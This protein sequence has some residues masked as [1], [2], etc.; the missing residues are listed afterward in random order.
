MS[1][2]HLK[3]D[4]TIYEPIVEKNETSGI[5][6]ISK[7]VLTDTATVFYFDA[8]HCV[9]PNC[10]F[11][12]SQGTVLQ[13]S[14]QTYKIIGCDDIE[15]GKRMQVSESGH[16][17][18]VIYFEPVDKSEKTVDF[19][20]GDNSEDFRITGIKLFQVPKPTRAV[21][22]TLK[23]EVIGR[24]QSSRLMLMKKGEDPRI[25]KKTFIPIRDGKFEYVLY[26]DHEEL[27]DLIFWDE[28]SQGGWRPISFIS[29]PEIINFTLYAFDQYG[30]NTIEGGK[31]N[32]EYLNCINEI[33]DKASELEPG[34]SVDEKVKQQI[35]KDG[36]I[37]GND[38]Y[39]LYLQILREDALYQ[40]WLSWKL[41]YIK[42][43][44]NIVGYS[45]LVS[46]TRNEMDK[47]NNISQYADAYQTLFASNYPNH[48]YTAKMIDIFTGSSLKAGI[49]FVDFS[50]VD[51]MGNPVRLSKQI[52]GKPTVLHLWASWC[53]PCRQKGK[54]LIPIYEEFREKGFTVVGVAREKTISTAEAVIKSDKFP[55]ENLVELN[56]A[57]QIWVKYGIGNSGGSV[58]LIDENGIIVMVSPSIDEIRNYL[59]NKYIPNS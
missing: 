2:C 30:M 32:S 1:S 25:Q 48:P 47:T 15:L 19:K 37:S 31:L 58:F 59:R 10:W 42:E 7:I 34:K 16:L 46:E 27:Y 43:H 29:E 23:G 14:G 13:G 22:C 44:P 50:A 56:D 26:C 55:W 8:Y 35:N 45:I 11:S 9:S 5:L 39:S 41:Q 54:E 12:I 36:W 18:F 40:E 49:P 52:A 21:S 20:D 28:Y 57:E 33:S 53:G 17:D 51:M 4:L 3:G 24:P 38:E 6:E